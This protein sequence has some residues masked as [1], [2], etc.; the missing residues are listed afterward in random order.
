MGC[1]CGCGCNGN[2]CRYCALRL[3]GPAGPTGPAGPPGADCV[4]TPGVAVPLLEAT[5]D[6]ATVIARVNALITSLT[7]AGLLE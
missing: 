3:R 5:D 6:L 7:D 4:V 2:M 1:N